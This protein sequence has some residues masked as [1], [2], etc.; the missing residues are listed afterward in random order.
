[1]FVERVGDHDAA[2]EFHA[3][4]VGRV[5]GVG[6]EDLVAGI[7]EGH[8]DVHDTLLGADQGI[9]FG[10]EVEVDVIPFF[11]PV[12]KCFAEDGFALIG[13]VLVYIGSLCLFCQPVDDGLMGRK[14]GATHGKF[15]DLAARSRFNLSYFAQTTREIVLSDTVHAV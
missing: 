15:Y 10:L 9:Y 6:D 5:S 14:V 7:E 11:I 1:M 3:C 4:G 13:H 8:A 2:G 12:G